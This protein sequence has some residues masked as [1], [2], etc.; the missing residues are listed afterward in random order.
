MNAGMGFSSELCCCTI[1]LGEGET[2]SGELVVICSHT[3]WKHWIYTLDLWKSFSEVG[4]VINFDLGLYEYNLGKMK[5]KDILSWVETATV[6]SSPRVKPHI[7]GRHEAFVNIKCI[8]SWSFNLNL[9][10]NQTPMLTP[11]SKHQFTTEDVRTDLN[12]FQHWN[13]FTQA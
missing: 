4:C 9:H 3:A 8:E 12:F 1:S 5:L 7:P 2:R 13:M 10:V 11:R 6:G